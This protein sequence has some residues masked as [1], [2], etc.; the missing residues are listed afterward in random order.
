MKSFLAP[1]SSLPL[2]EFVVSYK[3]KYVHKLLVNH[4]VKLAQKKSV[5]RWTDCPNMT[6]AVGWDIKHN[7]KPKKAENL[8]A[9]TYSIYTNKIFKS[10]GF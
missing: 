1:F 4:L 3:R 6:I 8:L 10:K 2:I 5:V 7:T 9:G